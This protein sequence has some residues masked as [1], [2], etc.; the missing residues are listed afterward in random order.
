MDMCL[1]VDRGLE[2]NVF[3]EYSVA[4]FLF[5]RMDLPSTYP[6]HRLVREEVRLRVNLIDDGARTGAAIEE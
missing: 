5:M 6:F 2:K 1:A 3:L 4:H